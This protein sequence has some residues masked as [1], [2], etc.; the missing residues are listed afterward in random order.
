LKAAIKTADMLRGDSFVAAVLVLVAA[1]PLLFSLAST[2]R[3]S[4]MLSQLLFAVE[5]LVTNIA[6]ILIHG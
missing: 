4:L 2:V 5:R 6:F 3:V 1:G